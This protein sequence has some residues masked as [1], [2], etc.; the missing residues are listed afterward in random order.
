[1]P[2]WG[3]GSPESDHETWELVHFIRHL[4]QLSLEE[5]QE[6]ERL[7]PKSPAEFEEARRIEDFLRGGPAATPA[8]HH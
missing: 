4:P 6:M 1:M 2:A 8:P 7:N 5:V 3:D